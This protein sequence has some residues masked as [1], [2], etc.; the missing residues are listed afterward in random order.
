M[1]DDEHEL[2]LRP[3][4]RHANRAADL[5]WWATWLGLLLATVG[6][7][8]GIVMASRKR[9]TTCPDGKYFP[10]GTTDFNCY[11]HPNV[12]LGVA[13]AA[14]SVVL[15]I[16]LAFGAVAAKAVLES[17]PRQAGN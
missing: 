1:V 14:L 7:I 17:D 3:V 2:P 13:I 10:E 9:V 16:V 5:V 6:L 4:A 11:T 12:E 15:G 8:D